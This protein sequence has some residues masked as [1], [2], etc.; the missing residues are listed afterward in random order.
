MRASCYFAFEL[1]RPLWQIYC[2]L[3]PFAR[4]HSEVKQCI[5]RSWWNVPEVNVQKCPIKPPSAGR[6]KFQRNRSWFDL[7]VRGKRY[8]SFIKKTIANEGFQYDA[9][10]FVYLFMTVLIVKF[11]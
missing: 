10:G 9:R 6:P 2:L 4:D 11:G 7:R 1:F 3:V 8:R 5:S